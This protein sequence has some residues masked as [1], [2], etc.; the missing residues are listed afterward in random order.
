MLPYVWLS[1]AIVCLWL[2]PQVSASRLTSRA[3][4]SAGLLLLAVAHA[5][6]TGVVTPIGI[7]AILAFGLLC[8]GY[9][10]V[11][12]HPFLDALVTIAT[13]VFSLALM[14]HVVPGFS[15]VLIARDVVLSPDAVPYTLFLNFDKAQI[16]LFL[17]A[18]GPPLIASRADWVAMLTAALPRLGLLIGIV[19]VCAFSIGQ[20]RFDS[21]WP[22]FF[23]IW[24]SANL[25]FTCAAEEALFRGVIQRRLQGPSMGSGAT[26]REIA[27]LLIA[28]V[29]FGVA[30][31]AGGGSA[32]VL[33]TISGIG[34][35]WIYWRTN[36]IEGSILAHF[37]LNT[38]HI[39]FFTYPALQ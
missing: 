15:N 6:W 24:V 12:C 5:S 39:L 17:L 26:P 21:K 36:R 8:Y 37:L 27:G 9:S 30:H 2:P 16:G 13:I 7:L 20:V 29:L 38:T 18:F 11:R 35:G 3:G 14:A 33:A 23:P 34:Y 10:R 1:L 32:I 25:L 4:V 28:S 19:M 31:F 22:A